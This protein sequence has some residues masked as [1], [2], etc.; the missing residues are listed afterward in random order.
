MPRGWLLDVNSSLAGDSVELW[1][2]SEE[3]RVEGRSVPYRPPFFVAGP[4]ERLEELGRTLAEDR[5]VASVERVELRTD[6]FE[7]PDRRHPALSVVPARHGDRRALAMRADALGGYVTFT[8]FDVDLTAPQLYYIEH[9]LYP[10]APVVWSGNDVLAREAADV[11]EY[12]PPPL[13]LAEL[14]VEV[15]G[16]RKGRLPSPSDPLRAVTLGGERI[17]G[18][19]ERSTLERLLERLEAEDPDLLVTHGGDAFDVP[20]LYRRAVVHGFDER[21]FRLGRGPTRFGLERKG[22]TF[23]SYGRILHRAPTY[24]LVG[25]I[26]LDLGAQFVADVGLEGFVDMARLSRL[27]LHVVSR[28]S[29]GTAFSSMELAV[30]LKDGVHIAWKKNYP[31]DEKSARLLVAADRGGFILTPPVGLAVG[32]D[33]FDFASL[34][35][36]IMV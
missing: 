20:Q 7:P 24:P 26:H 31:E 29:P 9:D 6:L 5:R 25:R 18:T 15:E 32:I 28:Q 11:I 33:E 10:F 21:R 12:D 4:D 17:E 19:D 36:A 1:L 2:K 22:R 34:F 30:A 23:E 14:S 8:L 3:G 16:H 27:S 13:V 35:P